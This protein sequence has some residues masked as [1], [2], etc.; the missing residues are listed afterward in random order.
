MALPG[1]GSLNIRVPPPLPGPGALP[2]ELPELPPKPATATNGMSLTEFEDGSVELSPILKGI[3]TQNADDNFDANLAESLVGNSS[4]AQDLLD[5]IDAD[6]RSRSGWVA[7]YNKGLELLGINITEAAS[8][9]GRV[10]NISTVEHPLL[11]EAV[12][13]FQS[14]ARAELMPAEGP[15]KVMT[16]GGSD[17]ERDE[18]AGDLESDINN[19][20]TNIDK[21]NYPD[22]DRGLFGLGFS[23]NTFRKVFV[24]PVRRIPVCRRVDVDDL[25]VSQDASDLDNALRV[26]QRAYMAPHLVKRYMENGTFLDVELSDAAL[27]LDSV[28]QKQDA[29]S[30]VEKTTARPAET[31]RTIYSCYTDL[32]PERDVGGREKGADY[33]QLLPYKVTIDKDTRRILEVRR[34]WRQDDKLFVKR[35]RFVHYGLV[36]GFD[37]LCLGYLHLLGNQ[38]RALRS[39]WR[40]LCD[41]GMYSNFPGG[42]KARNVRTD[43]NE[44]NPGPGEWVEVDPGPFDDIRQAFMPMPYKGPDAVFIQLAEIIGGDAQRLAGIPEMEVGE[45][46][47]N[48]PVGTVMSMIEQ[49]TQNMA[50][51]HKRMHTAQAQ[52]LQLLLEEFVDDPEA[53]TRFSRNPKKRVWTSEQIQ[54]A[55]LV[56]ASDPNI[57]SQMHR[58]MQNMAI[59]QLAGAAPQLYDQKAVHKRAIRSIG[60]NDA[61]TLFVPDQPPGANAGPPPEM[62]AQIVAA[63]QTADELQ[64]KK[65]DAQRKASHELLE[66]QQEDK[67]RQLETGLQ[68][69]KIQTDLQ[70]A[71]MHDKT[72]RDS[73]ALDALKLIHERDQGRAE[74][75]AQAFNPIPPHGT[76]KPRG[77][78][79]TK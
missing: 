40:I 65:D 56:P 43:T 46:R 19:Y 20:L 16:A 62:I 38:T 22:F 1:N 3:G 14:A 36:P 10:R 7:N 51:V 52:E 54:N 17:K 41:A 37:F 48:V 31:L 60:I 53:L 6:E 5:G 72:E 57:P 12:V 2:I 55:D 9:R 44:I 77:P 26:T 39:I 23:G 49:A 64:F 63:K 69:Q 32:D 34:N 24:D 79:R 18:L 35:Q 13:K 28:T 45:G 66:A 67:Q 4:L 70:I 61:D 30:G 74:L 75:A 58:M 42:I 78:K 50:A 27:A 59:L 68:T 47:T 71:Q 29:I 73:L 21:G 76:R 8:G 33:D 15:A 25:I 11:L